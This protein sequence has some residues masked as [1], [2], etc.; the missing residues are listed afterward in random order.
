MRKIRTIKKY[1][2][3]VMIALK[4]HDIEDM[5]WQLGDNIDISDAVK[6]SADETRIKQEVKNGNT[7]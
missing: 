2:N 3:T 6:V 4:P 5:G 7:I 1:G